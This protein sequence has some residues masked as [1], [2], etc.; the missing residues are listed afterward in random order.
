MLESHDPSNLNIASQILKSRTL[1]KQNQ[2]YFIRENCFTEKH[3][4]YFFL[5]VC[6]FDII[7]N[8]AYKQGL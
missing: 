2:Y 5:F 8:N 1:P 4:K 3:G 6:L 7:L